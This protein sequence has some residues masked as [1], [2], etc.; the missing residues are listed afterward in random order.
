MNNSKN[1]ADG[2]WK[3]EKENDNDSLFEFE[4]W[5]GYPKL[6]QP[7][8]DDLK[9]E[10]KRFWSRWLDKIRIIIRVMRLC[11]NEN[12]NVAQQILDAVSKRKCR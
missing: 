12:T 6:G 11:A 8:K 1:Y 7:K 3:C 10:K 9:L 5:D 4:D 2:T